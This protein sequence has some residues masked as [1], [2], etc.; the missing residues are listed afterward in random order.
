MEKPTFLTKEEQ[1]A[2]AGPEG[3]KPDPDPDPETKR[4]TDPLARNRV[5][6]KIEKLNRRTQNSPGKFPETKKSLIQVYFTKKS[7]KAKQARE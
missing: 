3:K 2:R 5:K 4:T 1:M 6:E 7:P